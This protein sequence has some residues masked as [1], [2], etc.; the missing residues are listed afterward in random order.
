RMKNALLRRQLDE[1][2]ELLHYEWEH[3]KAL[4]TRISNPELDRL[5]A[6][7]REHGALGGKITGAGGGG[8]LLLYC[9]F[10]RR[11]RVASRMKELGCTIA[12]FSWEPFGL[13]TW[14]VREPAGDAAPPA[15]PAPREAVAAPAVGGKAC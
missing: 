4:S 14:R 8:Y 12:D 10:D 1:F 11:H 2:G 7:A 3:K 5:Y 15:A 13:Q 6:I 9:A